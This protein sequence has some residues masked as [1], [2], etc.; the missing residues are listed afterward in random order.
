MKKVLKIW[1]WFCLGFAII[2]MA[3]SFWLTGDISVKIYPTPSCEFINW[4][5][6]G[7]I[8]L[9][10]ARVIELLEKK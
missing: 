2:S 10:L 8:S 7:L 3:I 5:G 9:G 6:I 4:I 1:G